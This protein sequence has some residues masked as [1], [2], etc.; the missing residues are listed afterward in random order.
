M[1]TGKT[2]AKP[3]VSIC[4]ITKN[5]RKFLPLLQQCIEKQTYPLQRIEWV[6]L[7]DS[8]QYKDSAQLKSTSG[9]TIKYQRIRTPLLLGAK[10]NLAHRLCSHDTIVYMDDD[11]YYFPDRVSHAVQKLQEG[12]LNIAGSTNLLIY[13]TH[14]NQ[15]WHSGPFGPYHATAG[16][17]AL[18]KAILEKCRFD[19]AATCNE[20]KSF[21]SNYTIPMT[22]LDPLK[23]MICISHKHNTF[24]K[25]RMRTKSPS[26][27]MKRLNPNNEQLIIHNFGLDRYREIAR[28]QY[29]SGIGPQSGI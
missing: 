5:R 15:I 25:R 12:N 22:Q 23:T 17:F 1:N 29:T 19:P 4:T 6:V 20:E 3:Y 27:R 13:F 24:D 14:D 18:E 28:S 21:L 16:T 7:D 8:D 11:D 26:P 9:I 10:R 2:N